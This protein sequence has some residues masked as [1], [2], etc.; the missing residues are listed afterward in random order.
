MGLSNLF[1]KK[2]LIDFCDKHVEKLSAVIDSL[3]KTLREAGL[4]FYIDQLCQIKSAAIKQD[5]ETFKKLVISRELFGGSGALLEIYIDDSE[6]PEVFHHQFSDF[7]IQ[8]QAMGI[9]NPRI[10]Q[11]KRLFDK[12]LADGSERAGDS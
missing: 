10:N 8:L 2:Q 3:A 5:E 1:K 6:L 12:S 4:S 9:K 7:I 11:T